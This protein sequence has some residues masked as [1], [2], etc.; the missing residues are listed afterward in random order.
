MTEMA[1][2][3][4]FQNS[5]TATK[6]EALFD[7]LVGGSEQRV[8]NAETE[9]LRGLEV[10]NQLVL[11]RQSVAVRYSRMLLASGESERIL[12]EFGDGLGWLAVRLE[13]ILFGRSVANVRAYRDQ[14][15]TIGN[16]LR[17]VDRL[18]DRIRV[19]AVSGVDELR[20]PAGGV[21]ARDRVVGEGHVGGSG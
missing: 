9:Q 1:L 21:K 16:V 11:R 15:R 10:D 2:A 18:R 4:H 5:C 19:V 17:E 3:C 13:R 20:M 14:R 8:R 12:C 7:D 6:K